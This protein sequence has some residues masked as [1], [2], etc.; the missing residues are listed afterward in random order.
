MRGIDIGASQAAK[1]QVFARR[2]DQMIGFPDGLEQGSR[3]EAAISAK[4]S[5]DFRRRSI[6]SGRPISGSA[7]SAMDACEDPALQQK[8]RIAY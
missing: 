1:L 4:A 6:A 3:V 7:G 5:S 8:E 2:V